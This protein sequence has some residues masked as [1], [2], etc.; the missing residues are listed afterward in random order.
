[1]GSVATRS[2]KVP[3]QA[4]GAYCAANQRHWEAV[5]LFRITGM[6][7]LYATA[8]AN[9]VAAQSPPSPTAIT[10]TVVAASK[11]PTVTE[12]P[13]Y[14]RAVSVT[15]PPG[16]TSTVSAANGILYQMSGSTEIV[17]DDRTS[18]VNPG[19]GSFIAAGKQVTLK[20]GGGVPSTFLHFVLAPAT[21]LN[22][23]AE[24]APATVT[25]LYRTSAAI[26]DL[27]PGA[28]DLNLTRVTFPALMPTNPPHHRSG[29][30]L[31]YIVSGTGSNTVDGRA[32]AKGPGSL[33]YEPFDL[34]H[35]WGNPGSEPFTF[36]AF[37]IN[38]EGVAA[39]LPGAPAKTQ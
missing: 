7:L 33:I 14:F 38:P 31:Y 32:E 3:R 24:T 23:T 9:S 2:V 39:V 13:L 15:L 20:A 25:E 10:R 18:T 35:Q 8:L 19:E 26:P 21:D 1:M 11:L 22:R 12:V 6:L 28:Y 27:K 37:N 29:A 5:M 36:L 4:Q 16:E 17:A 30:A 34:V